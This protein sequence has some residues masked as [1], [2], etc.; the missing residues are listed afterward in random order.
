MVRAVATVVSVLVAA[1]TASAQTP[2]TAPPNPFGDPTRAT[3]PHLTVESSVSHITAGPGTRLN[4]TVQV[5]P[6]REMHVYAPGK[7]DYQV[8]ALTIDPQPWARLEPTK[9]PPSEK[10]YF[11]PLNETVEVYSAAFRLTRELT[12]LDTAEARKALAGQSS[13][14]IAGRLEYQAC[15]DKVC[16]SPSKVPVRFAVTLK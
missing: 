15:D 3:T 6:R 12:I 16:Y 2:G 4:V 7:H 14:T 1:A 11:A 9:Y 8:V 13:L 10:Y 5:T